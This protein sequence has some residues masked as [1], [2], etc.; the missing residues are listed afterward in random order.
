MTDSIVESVKYKDNITNAFI[1]LTNEIIFVDKHIDYA[2]NYCSNLNKD[3]LVLYK[4]FCMLYK[5]NMKDID[6]DFITLVLS[7]DKIHNSNIITTTSL[8][9][10]IKYYNYYLMDYYIDLRNRLVF[11]GNRYVEINRED[12]VIKTE[13]DSKIQEEINNIKRKVKKEDRIYFMR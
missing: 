6:L 8:E 13:I 7:Y 4:N 1:S 3:E 10:H 9:P 12:Y 2:S 5:G 11:D